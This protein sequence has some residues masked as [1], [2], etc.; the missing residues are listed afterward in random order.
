MAEEQQRGP[1]TKLQ[2]CGIWQRGVLTEGKAVVVE[3]V[4]RSLCVLVVLVLTADGH[5]RGAE[6]QHL[7][8]RLREVRKDRRGHEIQQAVVAAKIKRSV[9]CFF[10][11]VGQTFLIQPRPS[12]RST[13][14]RTLE[15]TTPLPLIW[16]QQTYRNRNIFVLVSRNQ[17]VM[18]ILVYFS[19]DP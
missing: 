10:P 17:P 11:A 15:T 7:A 9:F 16:C 3:L 5:E 1:P 2:R 8:E 4:G 13:L 6:H 12:K 14:I 18:H 19:V